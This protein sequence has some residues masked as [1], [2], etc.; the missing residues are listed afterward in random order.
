M[1]TAK[2]NWDYFCEL[3]V[4]IP[5]LAAMFSD[6]VAEA[7]AGYSEGKDAP[8]PEECELERPTIQGPDF[9]AAKD[10]FA[11]K[12][13]PECLRRHEKEKMETAIGE[14]VRR[15]AKDALDAVKTEAERVGEKIEEVYDDARDYVKKNL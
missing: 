9:P 1:Y 14:K 3:M 12:A 6:Q 15:G 2:S 13:D 4:V 5:G 11:K 10:G 7:S 8:G